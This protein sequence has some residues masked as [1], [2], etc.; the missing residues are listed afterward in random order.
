[1]LQTNGYGLNEEWAAF[2]KKHDFLVGIS[3]DGIM[4]IHDKFRKDKQGGD[5]F[6]TILESIQILKKYGVSVNVLTVVTKD[7][8]SKVQKVYEFYKK[9]AFSYLQFIPCLEPLESAHADR[10]YLLSA[11]EYG[12]FLIELFDLWYLDVRRGTQPYIR[13]FENYINILVGLEPYACD[14]KGVCSCQYVIEADGSVYPCDFYVCDEY[15][16]GNLVQDSYEQIRENYKKLSFNEH[17]VCGACSG[18]QYARIC[19]GGCKRHYVMGQN[20][21]ENYYC[22]SYQMF[23]AHAL[24]KMNLLARLIRQNLR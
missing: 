12:R 11:K 17:V 3:V 6:L 9:N 18:C 10:D 2:F 14:Q 21:Y 16:I 19:L 22:E 23:F 4:R 7:L 5:T 8:A 24:G 13:M 1:M 15:I 20:G